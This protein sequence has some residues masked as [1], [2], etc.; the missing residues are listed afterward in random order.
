[1]ND[2][3]PHP[4]PAIPDGFR[5]PFHYGALHNVGVDYLV[6]LDRVTRHLA[7]T[8]LSPAVLD[9]KACVSFNYQLYFAQFDFGPSVTQEIELNIIAFPTASSSLVPD[10]TYV[11]FAHGEDQTK[12]R[13]NWRIQVACDAPPAIRAGKKLFNEPKFPAWFKTTMPSPNA[14]PGT[15]WKVECLGAELTSDGDDIIKH[16]KP[17]FS[18]QADLSGLLPAPVSIA[19]FT[20]YGTD[21]QHR[22]LAAPLNVYQ[23]YQHY[24]LD[25]QGHQRVR[26]A[27]EDPKS[28]IGADLAALTKG[29]HAVGVWTYQ[30]PT[31]AAQNRPYYTA[32][33]P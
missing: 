33:K 12:L 10:L 7:G 17:L 2:L 18:F 31:V 32:T 28:A 21:P 25:G 16:D 15:V 22:T 20:E 8:G 19:P 4:L 23:P 14:D 27:V 11:Q 29:V 24:A 3:A 6:P 26:L 1:M 30:S 5:L 13:G 9:G